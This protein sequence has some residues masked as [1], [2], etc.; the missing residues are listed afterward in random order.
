M[1]SSKADKPAGK[2]DKKRAAAPSI[3]SAD[4]RISGNLDTSGQ[5]QID[6]TVNGD[7]SCDTL[8]IGEGA[9]IVGEVT[10]DS[11]IIH[12]RVEGRIKAKRV[13]LSRTARITGDI[14]HDSLS[15]EA[16]AFLDG[17][18]R[19]NEAEPAHGLKVMNGG[20]KATTASVATPAETGRIPAAAQH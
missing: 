12:G 11:V 20:D 4:L 19:R 17:H 14:W 9:S 13:E 2:V 8:T 16:G 7:V 10:A 15:I 18:C 6:G 1:F 5:M 3:I